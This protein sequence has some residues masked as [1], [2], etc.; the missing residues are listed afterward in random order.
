MDM[1]TK[2]CRRLSR[3]PMNLID[4]EEF[5]PAKFQ[6][7]FKTTTLRLIT[8]WD[9][10]DFGR[11]EMFKATGI[12]RKTPRLLTDMPPSCQP[13]FPFWFEIEDDQM[14]NTDGS[15][16][17]EPQA[18]WAP[19][20]HTAYFLSTDTAGIIRCQSIKEEDKP[21]L[22]FRISRLCGALFA[23][24][25]MPAAVTKSQ[26]DNAAIPPALKTDNLTSGYA[27]FSRV[28]LKREFSDAIRNAGDRNTLDI[29]GRRYHFVRG[30]WMRPAGHDDRVWRKFHWRG[31]AELGVARKIFVGKNG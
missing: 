7:L 16:S 6:G 17:R 19:N 14:E 30:H 21:A 20:P 23:M 9:F 24:N 18:I 11:E 22:G 10:C 1:L 31:D 3:K 5:A 28:Y 29:S 12:N 4:L 2:L 15:V 27:L 26:T 13:S 8:N 25:E